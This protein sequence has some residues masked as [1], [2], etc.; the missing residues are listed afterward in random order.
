M[1]LSQA[2]PGALILYVKGLV[3]Q[4]WFSTLAEQTAYRGPADTKAT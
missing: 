3:L 4:V 1:T 2:S